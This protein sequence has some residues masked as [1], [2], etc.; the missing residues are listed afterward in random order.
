M[1]KTTIRLQDKDYN[2]LKRCSELLGVN[3]TSII[4]I[5]IFEHLANKKA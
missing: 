4:T 3:I 5:A 1:L 2:N